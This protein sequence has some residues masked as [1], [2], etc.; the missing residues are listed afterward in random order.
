MQTINQLIAEVA[1][2]HPHLGAEGVADIVAKRATKAQ[3]RPLIAAEVEHTLRT[4]TREAEQEAFASMCKRS[5]R[6]SEPVER[7][8]MP[9]AFR[10][11]FPRSF[12]VGDGN[13]VAWGK[14]T[15]EQHEER[16]AF[17]SRQRDGINSTI[18]R[19]SRAA[20][21]LR[22]TGAACLDELD[23]SELTPLLT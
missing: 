6:D 2:E 9:E 11:L 10:R 23:D 21:I 5:H 12:A 8:P 1:E 17:L 22:S 4:I 15:V 3:T 19:H 7:T 18:E 14:A 13:H 20:D 16:V